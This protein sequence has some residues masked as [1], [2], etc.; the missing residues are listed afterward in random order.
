MIP[1]DIASPRNE[2]GVD[3]IGSWER[4]FI[5][6]MFDLAKKV[7]EYYTTYMIQ[8]TK[9]DLSVIYIVLCSTVK[10]C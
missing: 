10:S 2:R 5:L 9:G 6:I 1:S 4:M 7:A 8:L 3:I